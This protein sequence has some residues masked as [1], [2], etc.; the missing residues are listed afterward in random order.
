MP[1]IGLIAGF[2]DAE[3]LPLLKV[4]RDRMGDL[5]WTEGKNVRY[6][7][8]AT[9]GDFKK[10]SAEAANLI[11]HDVDLFVTLGTPGL[12]AV[13]E[14][15]KTVPVVFTL[16]ADPVKLGFIESLAK[17]GGFS[18]GFTNFELSIGGKWLELLRD[19]DAS[20]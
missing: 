19:L 1:L 15:S 17:P 6:E 11:E 8:H 13:R 3:M 9:A 16:V 4:F 14:H 18:T 20:L 10:L 12:A 5:G 2:S 7:L